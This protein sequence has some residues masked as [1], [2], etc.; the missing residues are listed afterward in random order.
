MEGRIL[1]EK[2]SK[3]KI[4]AELITEAAIA[5]KINEAG[6]ALIGADMILKNGNVINKTGSLTLATVCKFNSIPFYVAADKAKFS[7]NNKFEQKEMPH[8][9]IWRHSNSKIKI[10]NFY[11]EEIDKKFISRIFTV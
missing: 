11:F 8:K 9:E 1:A 4:D 3:L 7:H 10:K 2:L 6:A 5:L